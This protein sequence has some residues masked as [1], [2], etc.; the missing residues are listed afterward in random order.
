MATFL[1]LSPGSGDSS[2]SGDVPSTKQSETKEDSDPVDDANSSGT[3]SGSV[4]AGANINESV[5]RRRS[6]APTKRTFTV[7]NSPIDADSHPSYY[8]SNVLNVDNFGVSEDTDSDE[9][10]SI[11]RRTRVAGES[12]EA[13]STSDLSSGKTNII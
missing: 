5:R 12:E 1:I 4:D 7:Y 13:G 11:V 8:T 10:A 2:G 3:G 6:K 9:D